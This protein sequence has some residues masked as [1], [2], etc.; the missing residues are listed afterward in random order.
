MAWETRRGRGR[1]YTRSRREGGR[2]VREYV[3]TGP[4]AELTAQV[5]AL[6]RGE[7]ERRRAAEAGRREQHRELEAALQELCEG[8]DALAR[9]ALLLAGYRQHNRGEWRRKRGGKH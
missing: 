6:A 4:L 1:Y 8:A 9:A 2:V 7:R 3:G 5:D